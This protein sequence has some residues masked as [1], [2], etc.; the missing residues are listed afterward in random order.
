MPDFKGFVGASYEGRSKTFDAQR[1]INLYPEV[2]E[3]SNS[4][5]VSALYGTP[6][7][8][9]F[10]TVGYGP[11]R[12]CV[13]VSPDQAF[14]V[15]G[16][17]VF[18]LATDGT[19]E[20]IGGLISAGGPVSM[21]WNGSILMLADG[22]ALYA[23]T[24][25]SGVAI[26]DGHVADRVDF[27][28]GYFIFNEKTTGRFYISGLYSSA[29]DELDFATAE[30]SPDDVVSLIVDHREV[31]LFGETTTEIWFNSGASLFPFERNQGAFIETGCA[32]AHSVAKMD[33]TVFWLGADDRGQGMVFRAEGFQP[34]RIST[35]A[36]EYQ[37]GKYGRIDDAVAYTYQQEGHSFY[38]LTFPSAG[39][40]WVYD[41]SNNMWHERAYRNT[42]GTFTR[43]RSN[44]HMA[45]ARKNIVGDFESGKLY[46]LDLDTYTDDGAALA[47]VRIAPHLAADLKRVFVASL[48]IDMEAGVGLSTGQGSD[49]KAVL[50]WSDDGGFKWSNELT[51]SIGAVGQKTARVR[52]RRLG[53]ARDRVFRLTI[54]DPVKVAIVGASI[55]ISAG[56]S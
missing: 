20:R 37:I 8:K 44:C 25:Q 17:D 13:R 23:Y 36:I 16:L 43:H 4:K 2:A 19:S 28:D 41:A 50:Q 24:G 22:V 35:H 55:N 30:G 11:I 6:G 27:V 49:P 42:D 26:I 53:Q 7:L 32:A 51:A 48:Q 46:A 15:S 56:Q 54:T 29:I 34:R 10:T 14:V 40:T 12:G 52:W 3:S 38:V 39:A 1:T 45:F 5:N 47:R 33:S 21:A 18:S 9:L 31:W